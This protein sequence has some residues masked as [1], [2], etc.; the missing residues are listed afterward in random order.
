M[1]YV[2]KTGQAYEKQEIFT[3]GYVKDEQ[4]LSNMITKSKEFPI[5]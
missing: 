1:V 5:S 3:T 4:Y 2:D